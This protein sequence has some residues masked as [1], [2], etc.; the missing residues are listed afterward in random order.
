LFIGA[1][2]LLAFVADRSWVRGNGIVAGELTAVSPIVQ[3]RLQHLIAHCLDHV[4]RGQILAEFNNEATVESAAQQ[5]QQLQLQLT[6]AKAGI[7]IAEQEGLAAAKLVEA[8]DTL[9]K[10]QIAVLDA[11]TELLKHRY[12]AELVWQQAKAAADRAEAETRAAEF[13]YQTKKADQKRAEVDA[14]VLQK[15][16]DSFRASPELTGHFFLTAPKDGMVTECTAREGEVIAARTPIFSIFNPNDTYAVV[17]FDPADIAK[18]AAGQTFQMNIEG[19]NKPVTGTVTD[20]YHELSA[21]PSSLTRY[22]WQREMWAQFAPVRLDFTNLDE[23][24]RSK[25]FAWAQLSATR[26]DGWTPA[27]ATAGSGSWQWVLKPINWA[28]QFVAASFAQQPR[29]DDG[30]RDTGSQTPRDQRG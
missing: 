16:I 3:A 4:K 23:A 13:V 18:V 22:F 30:N 9:W 1:A 2:I 29:S 27:N 6:Q 24:Q 11:E 15:R 7:D 14:D 8:Q 12:V 10:Q 20:F 5:L 28:W 17:F 25:L 21:L 26:F 19:I